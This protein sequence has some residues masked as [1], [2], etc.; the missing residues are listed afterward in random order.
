MTKP[1][2]NAPEILEMLT[3]IHSALWDAR[4]QRV[5]DVGKVDDIA[6]GLASCATYVGD[7]ASTLS[8]MQAGMKGIF[9]IED[10]LFGPHEEKVLTQA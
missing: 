8:N 10:I 3:Q 4:Q 5:E 6:M 2:L 7:A 9:A 1:N